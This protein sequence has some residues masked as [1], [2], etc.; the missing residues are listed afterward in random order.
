MSLLAQSRFTALDQ[1]ISNCEKHNYSWWHTER[2][3]CRSLCCWNPV[4]RKTRRVV[5]TFERWKW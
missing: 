1:R 3:I 5:L 2:F 4:H